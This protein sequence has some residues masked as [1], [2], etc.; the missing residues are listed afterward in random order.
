MHKILYNNL[1]KK[2]VNYFFFNSFK[3]KSANFYV[4]L[5]VFWFKAKRKRFNK[6][7]AEYKIK[8]ELFEQNITVS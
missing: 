4:F 7:R 5:S 2:K 3:L 8:L 1:R 6:I